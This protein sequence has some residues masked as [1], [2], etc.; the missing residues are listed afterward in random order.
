MFV[1]ILK[2]TGK[3]LTAEKF[4]QVANKFKY[5]YKDVSGAAK[6]P[7]AFVHGTGCGTL[8]ESDGTAYDIKV[9]YKCCKEVKL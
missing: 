3:D 1:R 8:V 7:K 4:L 6:F 5:K 2:K 9:P